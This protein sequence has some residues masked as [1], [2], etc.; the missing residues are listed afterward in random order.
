MRHW[1]ESRSF[2]G[3]SSFLVS[4]KHYYI[5]ECFFTSSIAGQGP[6]LRFP[7]LLKKCRHRQKSSRTF[8][9]IEQ[10]SIILDQST[11]QSLF[12]DCCYGPS[13]PKESIV[14][15][16]NL[17]DSIVV[18]KAMQ[19]DQ[20]EPQSPNHQIGPRQQN[21]NFSTPPR[22][23]RK[24]LVCPGAPRRRTREESFQDE[25][26]PA[27][28]INSQ[29]PLFPF[30]DFDSEDATLPRRLFDLE[31]KFAEPVLVEEFQNNN[32]PSTAN[33]V[34]PDEEREPEQQEHS[35]EQDEEMRQQESHDSDQRAT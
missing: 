18:P 28:S 16:E 30:E 31:P 9:W 7:G 25:V 27:H 23:L 35:S 22:T 3:S 29:A 2:T 15:I 32:Q 19:V 11:M 21:G 5:L 17:R 14:V 4:S 8:S 26:Y 1:Q 24:D 12:L 10:Q 6:G 33:V 20:Q 34:M 13:A